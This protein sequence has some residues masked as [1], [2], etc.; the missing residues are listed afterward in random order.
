VLPNAPL[1]KY[2]KQNLPL[3]N[4]IKNVILVVSTK[5][6]YFDEDKGIFVACP[7]GRSKDV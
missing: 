5:V 6:H 7:F 2:K 4:E 1:K 3:F